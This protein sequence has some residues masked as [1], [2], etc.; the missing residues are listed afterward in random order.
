MAQKFEHLCGIFI[1]KPFALLFI[2]VLQIRKITLYDKGEL[3]AEMEQVHELSEALP[4]QASQTY[5]IEVLQDPYRQ[6]LRT[7]S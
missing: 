6:V 2:D 5:H 7:L 3:I 1:I 4:S